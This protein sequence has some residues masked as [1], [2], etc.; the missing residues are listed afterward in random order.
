MEQDFHKG[1]VYWVYSC[2]ST[3]A[4]IT[5]KVEDEVRYI[6][7]YDPLGLVNCSAKDIECLFVNK[8][9]FKAEDKDQAMQFQKVVS[10]Y[11][12]KGINDESKWSSKWRKIEKEEAL[13]AEKERKAREEKDNTLRHTVVQR[14]AT[15]EKKK[16]EENE[17][18]RK[19]LQKKPKLREEKFKSL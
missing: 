2:L 11:F 13:K 7:V 1:F 12:Q 8:I 19:L 4:V 17:K 3:E 16:V 18:L 10:I 14:M 5:Y 15:E 6:S 9:G